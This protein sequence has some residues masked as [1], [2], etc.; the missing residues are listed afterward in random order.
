MSSHQI[1]A[2]NRDTGIDLP[3][4]DQLTSLNIPTTNMMCPGI[5]GQAG[6]V[7][8]PQQMVP[9]GFCQR[10]F[11]FSLSYIWLY[12]MLYNIQ[13]CQLYIML[14]SV[15]HINVYSQTLYHAT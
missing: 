1:A 6:R 12:S 7:Q 10:L 4:N 2:D 14:Y 11:S 13:Y 9:K 15:L 3:R 5:V 8:C